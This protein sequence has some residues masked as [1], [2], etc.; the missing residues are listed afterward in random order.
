MS[1]NPKLLGAVVNVEETRHKCKVGTVLSAKEKK[2]GVHYVLRDLDGVTF[3]VEN[4]EFCQHTVL[5]PSATTDVDAALNARNNALMTIHR[6]FHCPICL[7]LFKDPLVLKGCGHMYC[8][9]CLQQLVWTSTD[10]S[11]AVCKNPFNS[12]RDAIAVPQMA[13]AAA[14]LDTPL[15]NSI[16]ATELQRVKR[17]DQDAATSLLTMSATEASTPRTTPRTTQR[18]TSRTPKTT[19]ICKRYKCSKCGNRKQY[20]CTPCQDPCP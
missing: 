11:C 2:D 10:R 17:E 16:L 6:D 19:G 18:T 13:S 8:T 4:L 14:D 1:I 3:V 15:M 5:V 9:D 7:Q 12:L 20:K